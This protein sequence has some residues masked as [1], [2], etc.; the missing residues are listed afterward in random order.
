MKINIEID[1]SPKEAREFMGLP[2]IG[3]ANALYVDGVTNA[4]KNAKTPEQMKDFVRDLAPMGQ[5]G[6]KLMQSFIGAGMANAM[7]S[8]AARTD[9]PDDNS[10][11]ASGDAK[12][13]K[14]KDK[15]KGGD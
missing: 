1:C 5:A 10:S 3:E 6:L 4:M 8:G 11:G 9:S 13:G 15:G 14:P 2:D 12:K 7:N